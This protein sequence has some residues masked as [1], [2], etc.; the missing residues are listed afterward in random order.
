MKYFSEF[1]LECAK[2]A[3]KN[4]DEFIHA[5][6]KNG[7]APFAIEK[8][9]RT[10]NGFLG[11]LDNA[12][13]IIGNAP[14]TSEET[15]FH[16]LNKPQDLAGAKNIF[17]LFGISIDQVGKP[18]VL[19]GEKKYYHIEGT[20]DFDIGIRIQHVDD[21]GSLKI[22]LKEAAPGLFLSLVEM[23]IKR[24]LH[25]NLSEEKQKELPRITLEDDDVSPLLVLSKYI[26]TNKLIFKINKDGDVSLSK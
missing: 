18:D 25:F 23:M 21:N 7:R 6:N 3:K 20:Q 15:E 12:Y 19:F 2:S 10:E 13:E 26:V 8:S 11:V 24:K 17:L 5:L 22:R 9:W 4:K 16:F 1:Y 14:L